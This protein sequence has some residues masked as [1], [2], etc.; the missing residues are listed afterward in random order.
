MT[1]V[2]C[3]KAIEFV[4]GSPRGMIFPRSRGP[5]KF[6]SNVGGCQR[7]LLG[8]IK[9]IATTQCDRRSA[10]T[11]SS[12][13]ERSPKFTRA[14]C[15]HPPSLMCGYAHKYYCA[16]TDHHTLVRSGTIQ[17][18]LT[19]PGVHAR[20]HLSRGMPLRKDCRLS[21]CNPKPGPC[22]PTEPTAVAP[23]GWDPGIP[24]G[25]H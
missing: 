7:T 10:I 16:Q 23:A 11:V 22:E 1:I 20:C 6:M 21:L 25:G 17:G 3:L 8:G 9:P 4:D 5:G 24:R 2:L 19:P 13:Y 18:G 15:P 14:A 12:A